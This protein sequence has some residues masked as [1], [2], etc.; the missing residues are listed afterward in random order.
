[1]SKLYWSILH[2][3]FDTADSDWYP[4]DTDILKGKVSDNA[5]KVFNACLD[6]NFSQLQ[7]NDDGKYM[8]DD[9]Y[10][11]YIFDSFDELVKTVEYN[12]VAWGDESIKELDESINLRESLRRLDSQHFDLYSESYEL[13]MLY[14]SAR[15]TL[16]AQQKTNLD[17]FV[18]KAKTAEEVNTYMTGMLAKMKQ[19]RNYR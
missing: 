1:M 8:Y 9:W 10:D 11:Q 18:R 13:E 6:S 17:K 15:D 5:L 14:E 7:T 3:A 12:A 19:K 2:E 16:S 4:V